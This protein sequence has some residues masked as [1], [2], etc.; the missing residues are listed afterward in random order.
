MSAHGGGGPGV[1]YTA[2]DAAEQVA[3]LR[4]VALEAASRFG[5]VVRDLGL[6]LHGYN[7]T[8]RVDTDDGRRLALRVNTNSHSTAAHVVAQQEWLHALARDTDVLVPD[9]LRTPDGRWAVDVDCAAWGA[10]LRVTVASWLDGDD[11]GECDEEQA[12]AL[13]RAMALLHDHAEGFVLPEGA[14]LPCY[15]EPLFGDDNL[16]V[17]PDVRAPHTAVLDDALVECRR[18]F[19]EVARSTRPVVIHADLHGGNLK[20]HRGRVA[21]FDVDDAGIG[22]PAL[23]LAI[24][25]F[26]L[27][28]GHPAAEAALR[29]GY[30]DVRDLPDVTEE[31][32]EALVAARQLLLANSLFASSTA[33]LRAEAQDYLDVTV[34]RLRHWRT[35]GRFSRAV[36]PA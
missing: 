21:V 15:D 8:F 3:Q 13:G 6:V 29:A 9:P 10:A 31:Q 14:A 5:L 34:D 27:R 18:R 33:S 22:A 4:P 25:T 17:G 20:W 23:D 12:Y 35:T 24:S 19:D 2:M 16:L 26:Y 7:T 11:V 32:L 28:D 36:H 30:A 1:A